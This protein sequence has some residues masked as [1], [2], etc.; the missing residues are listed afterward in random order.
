MVQFFHEC[1]LKEL[2]RLIFDVGVVIL[3]G[4]TIVRIPRLVNNRILKNYKKLGTS[5]L[6]IYCMLKFH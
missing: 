5:R 1:A 6:I 2:P 3:V 4:S